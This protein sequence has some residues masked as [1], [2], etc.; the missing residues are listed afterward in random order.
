MLNLRMCNK[1]H[2]CELVRYLIMKI[3]Y[4][5]RCGLHF[6]QRS[7]MNITFIANLRNMIFFHYLSQPKQMIERVLIKRINRSPEL[8]RTL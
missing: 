5:R 8:I 1:E 3:E 7:E 4:F 2:H 6:S